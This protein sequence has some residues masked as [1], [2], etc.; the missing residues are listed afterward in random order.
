[1]LRVLAHHEPRGHEQRRREAARLL[2]DVFRIR[3]GRLVDRRAAAEERALA[4]AVQLPVAEF[5]ADGEAP[6][7]R[8]LAGLVGVDPDPGAGGGGALG[9][10][11]GARAAPR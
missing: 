8:P 6:A 3:V 11:P 7:R 4:V 9:E 5:V 2:L 1:D 10:R